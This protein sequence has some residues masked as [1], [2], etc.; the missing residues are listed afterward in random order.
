[1]VYRLFGGGRSRDHIFYFIFGLLRDRGVVASFISSGC[2]SFSDFEFKLSFN[3]D[4]L[5]GDP[6]LDFRIQ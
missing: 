5:S 3:D 1:M 6:W 4:I 2:V